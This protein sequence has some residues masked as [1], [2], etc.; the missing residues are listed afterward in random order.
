MAEIKE[1]SEK[2]YLKW[3]EYVY[4]HPDSNFF[5]YPVGKRLWRNHFHIS[6]IIIM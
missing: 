3:D 1:I 5:S 4:N 2:I 6:H